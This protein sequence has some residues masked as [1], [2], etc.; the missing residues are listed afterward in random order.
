MADLRNCDQCG[1][2]FEPR[3]EH[4]RFCSARCR[5]A[6]DHDTLGEPPL[7]GSAL[8]W[9]AAAMRDTGDQL[10]VLGPTDGPRAS[11]VVGEMVWWVTMVDSTL[12]RHH[13]GAYDRVLAGLALPRRRRIEGTLGGLRFV[14]NRM[15]ED[16]GCGRFLRCANDNSDAN[17]SDG[18]CSGALVMGWNWQLV[19][20]PALGSLPP[21]ARAWEM[22]RYRD[23]RAF[24]A[25]RTI[26]DT[27][28]LATAFLELAANAASGAEPAA[29][30]PAG[31]NR[32]R[33]RTGA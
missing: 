32:D 23:Y 14:R 18:N 11:S 20:E 24:L 9:S 13:P 3:R 2:L 10:A 16:D 4:A 26:G 12:V 7:G 30:G 28:G 27:F 6:W 31:R 25:G 22:T 19:P 21:R 15:R 33:P 5:A 1:E 8:H 17:G 29:Y